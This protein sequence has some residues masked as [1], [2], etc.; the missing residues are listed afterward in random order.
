MKLA[1]YWGW[2]DSHWLRAVY[3]HTEKSGYGHLYGGIA[4]LCEASQNTTLKK[5]LFFKA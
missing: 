4:Q 2:G 3:I 1:G 5:S